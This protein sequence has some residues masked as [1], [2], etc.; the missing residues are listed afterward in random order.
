MTEKEFDASTVGINLHT[1]A[2]LARRLIDEAPGECQDL[3]W[4]IKEL[5][6]RTAYEVDRL[7][8]GI[9]WVESK[10]DRNLHS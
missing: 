2:D 10:E 7:P 1:I 9:A 4:S 3:I 8:G 5:A 6:L